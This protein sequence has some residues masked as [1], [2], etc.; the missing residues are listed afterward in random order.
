MR[1]LSAPQKHGLRYLDTRGNLKA[2]K[3]QLQGLW[4]GWGMRLGIP[5][6]AGAPP[7]CWQVFPDEAGQRSAWL[8]PAHLSGLHPDNL[9]CFP[10]AWDSLTQHSAQK[11]PQ[12]DPGTVVS[13]SVGQQVERLHLFP[14]LESILHLS[15]AVWAGGSFGTWMARGKCCWKAAELLQRK[16]LWWLHHSDH[17]IG[18]AESNR[19]SAG[20]ARGPAAFAGCWLKEL[21]ERHSI[22][23]AILHGELPIKDIPTV[24]SRAIK[25][26]KTHKKNSLGG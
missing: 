21:S 4:A 18:L 3:T 23:L 25:I 7:G 1:H 6:L 10:M 16:E 8:P 20:E 17:Q 5:A 24:Y 11:I 22:S 15:C 12:P 14:A 26:K 13:S 2:A 19:G 9:K